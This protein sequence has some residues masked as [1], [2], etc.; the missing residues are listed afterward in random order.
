MRQR[1]HLSGF[2]IGSINKHQGRETIRKREAAKLFRIQTAS[3]IVKHHAAAHHHNSRF[4][5]LTNEE[6]QSVCPGWDT[7]APFDIKTQ[8]MPHDCP[9]RFDAAGHSRRANKRERRLS[10]RSSKVAIPLL[11]LLANVN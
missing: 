7:P 6:S 11:A 4:V 1:E 3:I 9:S 10:L 8:S 2:C 5:C